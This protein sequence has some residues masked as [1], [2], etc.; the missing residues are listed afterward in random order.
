MFLIIIITIDRPGKSLKRQ[1]DETLILH[2]TDGRNLI[3]RRLVYAIPVHQCTIICT[4]NRLKHVR[5][6]TALDRYYM[7]VVNV[8]PRF[9]FRMCA[10]IILILCSVH[11][12][13]KRGFKMA[14]MKNRL[15]VIYYYPHRLFFPLSPSANYLLYAKTTQLIFTKHG[16]ENKS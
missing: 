10:G 14:A 5:L 4:K 3:T 2:T 13:H 16:N 12:R 7:I 1:S 15:W 11:T 6:K 8:L 9:R